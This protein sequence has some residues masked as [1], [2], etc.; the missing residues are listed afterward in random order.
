MSKTRGIARKSLVS[1]AMLYAV[2]FVLLSPECSALFMLE[3]L[4]V[5]KPVLLLWTL[6][7]I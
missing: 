4:C 7:F 5:S 1:K 6:F 2:W 3:G